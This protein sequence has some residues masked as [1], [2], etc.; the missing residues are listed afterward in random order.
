MLLAYYAA[1]EK[2][3][4]V[5]NPRRQNVRALGDMEEQASCLVVLAGDN[6]FAGEEAAGT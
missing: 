4:D 6:R 5:S 2:A 1:D 3:I